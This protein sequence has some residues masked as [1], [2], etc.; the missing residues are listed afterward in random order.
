[1]KNLS[2]IAKAFA[3][4]AGG[5]VVF[6]IVYL[7]LNEAGI[8]P[9]QAFPE[10]WYKQ[11]V[12]GGIWAFLLLIPVLRGK[13]W[14]RGVIVGVLAS[15]AAIFFFNPGLQNAPVQ[16]LVMVFILNGVVWGVPAAWLND[17]AMRR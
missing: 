17:V 2:T 6:L 3:A 4:G 15:L 7:I 12:W 14:L 10:F 11:I 1:M 8:T 9:N 13:W 16:V 5:A